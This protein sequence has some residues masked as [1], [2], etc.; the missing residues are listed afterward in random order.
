MKEKPKYYPYL[1]ILFFIIIIG[2]VLANL[3]A[4]YWLSQK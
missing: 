1:D 3:L 4:P 2:F